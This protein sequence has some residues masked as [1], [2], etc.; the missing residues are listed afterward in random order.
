MK[1]IKYIKDFFR[2]IKILF[3]LLCN[4]TKANYRNILKDDEKIA[5]KSIRHGLIALLVFSLLFLVWATFIPISSAVIAQG[6][7]VI[8][9]NRKTVQHL[10]GGIVEKILVKEGDYV[11][12]TQ[13]LFYLRD[14]NA[15]SDKKSILT[16]LWS[17]ELQ[18]RRL[19]AE[20]N[21][22]TDFNI[23][24]LTK[25]NEINLNE[26]LKIELDEIVKTQKQLF[27]ARNKKAT[28]ELGVLKEK[29]KEAKNLLLSLK[30][31]KE[32]STKKIEIIKKELSLIAPLVKNNDI[33]I[34][35][36]IELE[37]QLIDNKTRFLEISGE[38]DK[39]MTQIAQ[40]K[41]QIVNYESDSLSKILDEIKQIE[42]EISTLKNEFIK[43]QDIVER[44]IISA[45]VAGKVMEIKY[46]TIGAVI[47]G[48][49]PILSIVP[50]DKNLIIE[51]RVRPQ[52]IDSI[53]EGLK[54]RISLTAFKE[55]KVPKL[56]G[57][58][59]NISGDII[60]DE[61]S[62]ESYYLAR[63]RIKESEIAKLKNE[64]KINP[65]MPA[66][67][68]IITGKRTM[69]DYLFSPIK[70]SAYKAFREE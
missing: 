31:Q 23:E 49:S 28:G 54:A 48:G 56:K 20:K 67:V 68:F 37:K 70:D 7:V 51:A 26:D 18:R 53:Y 33:E 64:I 5:D 9:F 46:H 11:K 43:N 45:P 57:E 8:D 13:P 66:Q 10:E 2:A 19:I 63:V 25:I 44:S 14:I 24:K 69:L 30:E 42:V 3:Y 59:I 16:K 4:V 35:K 12:K 47:Q 36:K 15:K 27:Q 32:S 39:T 29:L 61:K 52:D 6:V 34:T 40:H 65:G 62:N 17:L 21:H 38:I 1:L 55:K 41:L 60:T 22:E 58:V 50:K